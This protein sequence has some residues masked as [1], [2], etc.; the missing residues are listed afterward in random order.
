MSDETQGV[1]PEINPTDETGMPADPTTDAVARALNLVDRALVYGYQKFGLQSDNRQPAQAA[2][3]PE[4]TE[5]DEDVQSFKNGGPVEGDGM[6]EEEDPEDVP[7]APSAVEQ[8][9]QRLGLWKYGPEGRAQAAQAENPDDTSGWREAAPEGG[10]SPPEEGVD[11]E[12]RKRRRA[13]QVRE[14]GNKVGYALS[15][16]EGEREGYGMIG[17]AV[18]NVAS[19]LA[20]Q[21]QDFAE[22][23]SRQPGVMDKLMYLIRGGDALPK[24]QVL[25]AEAAAGQQ[26][27]QAQRTGKDLSPG[28]QRLLALEAASKDDPA[29]AWAFLQHY[30][31]KFDAA[32]AFASRAF[33]KQNLT[34]AIHAANTAFEHAL[35]GSNVMFSPIPRGDGGV[36]GVTALVTPKDSAPIKMTLNLAQFRNL[37]AGESG[38]YDS[39][40][41]RATT[42]AIRQAMQQPTQQPAQQQGA[43][44]AGAQYAQAPAQPRE[45]VGPDQE[46]TREVTMGR[47]QTLIRTPAYHRMLENERRAGGR[48]REQIVGRDVEEVTSSSGRTDLRPIPKAS[49]YASHPQPLQDIIRERARSS[50]DPRERGALTAKDIQDWYKNQAQIEKTKE[51]EANANT[52]N[53][54]TNAARLQIA[55]RAAQTGLARIASMENKQQQSIAAKAAIE[56]FKAANQWDLLDRRTQ[57]SYENAALIATGSVSKATAAAKEHPR[58]PAQAPSAGRSALPPSGQ[59]TAPQAAPQG[60]GQPTSGTGTPPKTQPPTGMIYEYS[61]SR[62]AWRLVPAQ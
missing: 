56:E 49:E 58:G 52:R 43:P 62:N 21:G 44:Q 26:V 61:K 50:S 35:D 22:G 15:P 1:I 53:R 55:E 37:I 25:A 46:N 5:D 42:G 23:F 60:G 4:A 8:N 34:S 9:R 7:A 11:W 20:K 10:G 2:V 27:Q 36:A 6:D 38:T 29:R 32:R 59:Q 48:P 19:G 40:M 14:F 54:E 33:D 30:R 41:N 51:H 18:G 47:D 3:D 39:V 28:D 45:A 17:T 16:T 24:D 57:Q 13:S 31:Q 12:E